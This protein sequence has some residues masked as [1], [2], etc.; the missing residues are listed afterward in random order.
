MKQIY[1]HLAT[2]LESIGNSVELIK[3]SKQQSSP[4]YTVGKKKSIKKI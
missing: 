3:A 2:I 4:K 1:E